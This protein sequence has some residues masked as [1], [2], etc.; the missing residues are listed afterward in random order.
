METTHK[1]R[2]R[3]PRTSS[4]EN[5][6]IPKPSIND[7]NAENSTPPSGGS[8]V[9]SSTTTAVETD[10]K[11]TEEIKSKK[12]ETYNVDISKYTHDEKLQQLL[13]KNKEI[14]D[15]IDYIQSL[16]RG[17]VLENPTDTDATMKELTGYFMYLNPIACELEAE[18][19][20]TEDALFT[21]FRVIK[22][23]NEGKP[24]FSMIEKEVSAIM[25]AYRLTRNKFIAYRDNCSTAISV[26]QSSLKNLEK[27]KNYSNLQ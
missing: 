16:F 23:K 6:H 12:V 27:E 10:N 4:M 21:T 3:P 8:N 20:N 15:K 11:L 22:E 1:R 18:K 2:G 24:V 5:I 9:V 17:G 7:A 13:D 14:F 25:S 19:K 26:C